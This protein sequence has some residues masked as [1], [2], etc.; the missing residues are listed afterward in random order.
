M[1]VEEFRRCAAPYLILASLEYVCMTA[2]SRH[3]GISGTLQQFFRTS[4]AYRYKFSTLSK[5]NVQRQSALF[6]LVITE[7]SRGSQKWTPQAQ[8]LACGNPSVKTAH[9][10]IPFPAIEDP[11]MLYPCKIERDYITKLLHASLPSALAS[12][13][14]LV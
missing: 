3:R 12:G 4:A 14:W 1:V 5:I 2:L 8:Q 6:Y 11:T 10:H 9:W 13:P 7:S